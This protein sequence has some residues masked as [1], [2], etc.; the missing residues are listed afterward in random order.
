MGTTLFE[1]LTKMQDN[2]LS[3]RAALQGIGT[4]GLAT[5]LAV[6]G[7]RVSAQAGHDHGGTPGAGSG[8]PNVAT[9]YPEVIVIAEDFLFEM[10]NSIEGGFVKITLDNQGK[11]DHHSMFLK[12]NE[13]VSWEDIEAILDTPDFGA[14]LGAV[15]SYGGN[16]GISPGMQTSTIIH[17]DPGL[18]AVVCAIPDE[19]GNPHYMLGMRRSLEVTEPT[20]TLEAPVADQ[21][22]EMV[23]F[24]FHIME[25]DGPVAAGPQLWAFP[26]AGQQIHEA[27]IARLEEGVT[28]EQ[29]TAALGF[30]G[31]GTPEASA[32]AAAP[33][34]PEAPMGPPPFTFVGGIGPMSPGMTNW[35]ALDLTPGEYFMICFVPDPATGAPHA[36][37]GMMMPF[38]VA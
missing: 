10:P 25:M 23:E 34:T 29:I 1:K 11:M 14:L 13:G 27:I 15:V 9:D 7:V 3:R 30:G 26:N 38:T 28:F 20:S 33:A 24:A 2:R 35:A 37:L 16:A 32:D 5:A 6:G 18:Y 12:L 36:A 4:A 31:P 21:T 8:T 17:L 19:E 22:V